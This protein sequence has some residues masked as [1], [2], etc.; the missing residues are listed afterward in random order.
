MS[1]RREIFRFSSLL[2]CISIL[3]VNTTLRH[4]Y[5]AAFKGLTLSQPSSLLKRRRGIRA[6]IRANYLR[7]GEAIHRLKSD[8]SAHE[9]FTALN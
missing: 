4:Y 8:L 5:C 9:F 2:K 7:S 6:A 1:S 3:V